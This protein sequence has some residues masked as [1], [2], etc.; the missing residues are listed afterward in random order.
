MYVFLLALPWLLLEI[1]STIKL[2]KANK[3]KGESQPSI[4]KRIFYQAGVRLVSVLFLFVWLIVAELDASSNLPFYPAF[5]PALLFAIYSLAFEIFGSGRDSVGQ[6]VCL[7]HKALRAVGLGQLVYLSTWLARLPNGRL[8][9]A[10][11]QDKL[12]TIQVGGLILI[13]VLVIVLIMY[14]YFVV[15]SLA[16][17]SAT[18]NHNHLF[19]FLWTTTASGSLF[20]VF[21]LAFKLRSAAFDA[22]DHHWHTVGAIAIVVGNLLMAILGRHKLV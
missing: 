21:V 1:L 9:I 19:G 6:L 13:P 5:I 10:D 15:S 14:A 22:G 20:G 11:L 4:P 12:W 8:E 18:F 3:T 2:L 16:S 7:V 17:K